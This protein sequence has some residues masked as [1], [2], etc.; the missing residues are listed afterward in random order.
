MGRMEKIVERESGMGKIIGVI[1][2]DGNMWE[3]K[4]S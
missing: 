4:R 2:E 3:K 1:I